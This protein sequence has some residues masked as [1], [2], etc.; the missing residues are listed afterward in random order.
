MSSLWKTSLALLAT[1][2]TANPILRPR[3]IPWPS[4]V[5]ASS[6]GALDWSSIPPPIY[7]SPASSSSSTDLK[8]TTTNSSKSLLSSNQPAAPPPSVDWRNRTSGLNYITTAQNQGGCNSCWAFAVTALIEA[9]V[10]IEHGAWSKRSEADVHHGVGAAC[11]SVGNAEETLAWVA[12][13]GI[14]FVNDTDDLNKA[15]P[16]I[17]DWPCDPYE[18]TAH[19]ASHC[20]DRSGRTTRIPFYQALGEVEDQ[21]RWVDG[22]GPLVATFVLYADFASGIVSADGVYRWDGVAESTGNHL[23]LVVGYDDE[24]QAWLIKNSWG[25][26]WAMDGF[27]YFGYD[28]A[29]IDSWTK[30]GVANVNPDPWTRKRHQSGSMLQSGN[31]ETHRNFELV[32]GSAADGFHHLSRDGDTSKWSRVLDVQ[33]SGL[34]GQPVIVG[35]SFNRD[36]HAV[37]VNNNQALQQWTYIQTEKKW[38]QVSSIDNQEIDGF[39]GLTQSDGSQLVIVV[40]HS[41]GTLNEVFQPL[42]TT[43]TQTNPPIASNIAQSGP[44]LVQSNIGLDMYDPEGTSR[45]NLY[46]VAVRTDGTL[47]LFWRRGQD[48]TNWSAGEVFGSGIPLDTPPAMIQDYFGTVNETSIGGFQL[49]IAVNGSVQHWQRINDD[50]H[51]RDPVEGEQ[52]KWRLVETAGTGVKHVWAL[53]QGSFNQKMHLVTEGMDGLLSYWEWEGEWREVETLPALDDPT[54]ATSEQATMSEAR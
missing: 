36:F 37:G 19:A 49:V 43:W 51:A 52:G 17:A 7:S 41:D 9:M 8:T 29:N 18:A 28:Q 26:G 31:G 45:G 32:T 6:I 14:M 16:G 50:V 20:V 40:K 48:T 23:A 54:W 25:K 46:T 33:G 5:P 3:Q 47:Q 10:R 42:L 2:A 30:Y 13:Q 39:P 11:E 53:V 15:P 35:T 34:V 24:K 4:P 27:V 12:G 38:S 21:K 22:Y 1:A 44:S